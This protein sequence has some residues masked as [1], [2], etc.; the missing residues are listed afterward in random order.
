MKLSK[1]LLGTTI[2]LAAGLAALYFKR[3][4][5]AL[6]PAV[7]ANTKLFDD[8]S[9]VD[10]GEFTD[11]LTVA[12]ADPSALVL[13][14]QQEDYVSEGTLTTPPFDLPLFKNLVASWNALTP[15]GTAVEVEARVGVDG[16]WSEW[17]SWGRWSTNAPSSSVVDDNDDPRASVD[18]DTLTVKAG[19]AS[20]AQLRVH[21]YSNDSQQT[22]VLKLVAASV[23]PLQRDLMV[24]HHDVQ[25][26]RVIPAPAYSQ[27]IRDPKLAPGIC[28]PTT[29][30]MAVNRQNADILPEEAALRNL[31]VAYG[32]FG[33]WSFSTAMAGSLGYKAYTAYTDLDG[34]RKQ[35]ALGLPVGVSVQYS[36]HQDQ[37]DYPYVENATGD[38]AGHLLLVTGFTKLDGV[39]YVAVNDSYA[40][41]DEDAKR[42]YK[43]DQF[44]E[45]WHSRVAY[46]IGENY[47]GYERL[48]QPNRVNVKLI[49]NE[50]HDAFQI[51]LNEQVI[52]ITPEMIVKKDSYDAS[53]TTVAYTLDDGGQTETTAQ[54][55]FAY[56]KT[57][58]EGRILLDVNALKQAHPEASTVTVYVIRLAAPTLVGTISLGTQNA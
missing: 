43:L 56:A 45:A 44:S 52:A 5:R 30:S 4:T 18:T 27:E 16:Y 53:T 42:L 33:N 46:M 11:H 48:M 26:D 35:I 39:D 37:A 21:L 22:P 13:A 41:S 15:A 2:G 29:I 31:D 17:H 25:V 40:D 36:N 50:A 47:A 49:A 28:S 34:L 23:K 20:Q 3:D 7:K 32:G 38:T 51:N 12:A 9:A 8:F 14:Q 55:H 58:D 6:A 1:F 24:D 54:Q 19:S 10:L 57:D